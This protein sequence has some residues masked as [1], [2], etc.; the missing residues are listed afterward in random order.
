MFSFYMHMF[1]FYP[2][3]DKEGTIGGMVTKA[4]TLL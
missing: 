3:S 2:V 4:F 1:Y